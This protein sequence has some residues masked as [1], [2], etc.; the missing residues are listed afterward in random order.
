MLKTEA[1]INGKY[2]LLNFISE[3]GTAHIYEVETADQ[4][5]AVLKVSKQPTTLFNNQIDNEAKTLA[6]VE[7]E[8]IPKLFDK[9]TVDRYHHGI[10]MEK[11]AGKPLSEIIETEKRQFHWHEVLDVA[12]QL[13]EIIKVFHKKNPPIVIRD[14]KPSNILLTEEKKVYLIDFGAS[15]ALHSPGKYKALGTIGY[16]APEQF[17]NGV[18]DVRSDLFSF[19]ATLFYIISSGKN[20]YTS[21]AEN[22]V[23]NSLPKSFA[24]VILKLTETSADKRYDAID[25]V[26]KKL[27]KVK[28]TMMERL[29]RPEMEEPIKT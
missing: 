9:V 8:G 6:A 15:V 25:Q 7:H 24:H 11:L 1:Y 19:G 2:K 12:K 3:G 13:A 20:V 14:I 22:V 29:L 10:V 5:R 4:K 26:I 27:N 21:N 17:E 16:A 18:I 28:P 23:S